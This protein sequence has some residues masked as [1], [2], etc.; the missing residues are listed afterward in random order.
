MFPQFT[1][2]NVIDGQAGVIIYSSLICHSLTIDNI[3]N[4]IVLLI[5]AGVTVATLT[6]DNGLLTKAGEAKKASEQ[7]NLEEEVK[8]ALIEGQTD[9]YFNSNSNIQDKLKSIFEKSYGQGNIDVTKAGKNYKVKV[10]NT[11]TV[12]RIKSDGTVEKYE[13]MAP[14]NVYA[15]LDDNILRLR[16][17]NADDDYKIYADS[18]S[19]V[20]SLNGT[21]TNVTTVDIEEPIAPIT[22]S[23]MFMGLT[24]LSAIEKIENFHTE[25]STSLHG[26]FN[27]CSNLIGLNL[28]SFDTSKVTSMGDMFQNCKKISNIDLS[29]FD[30]SNVT[31]MT[32]MFY[33]CNS[34][35]QIDVSHFD[36]KKVTK[37]D[38]M[39]CNCKLPEQIDVSN[40]DTAKV[41]TFGGMFSGCRNIKYMYL[42][43]FN[44][45]K[46]TIL[47]G[48]FLG[49]ENLIGVDLSSFDTSIVGNMADMFQNCKKI[50][51]I[52]LSSFN[53]SNV[54]N[55]SCMFLNCNSLEK[56]Y[57]SNN[58][59][60][61][62]VINSNSMFTN[63]NNLVG[64]L[65]T[66]SSGGDAT[67]AHIDE[68]ESNPGYFTLK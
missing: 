29:N 9:K 57:V 11:K 48:M 14:T 58:F 16:A 10:K 37:M 23:S 15:K 44:T 38:S 6:G 35:T 25:N 36:T 2:M 60:T 12:Y 27:G 50:S 51:N 31:T 26:M 46:A 63:T 17:T 55:M 18:S 66:I 64:G 62:K 61:T 28:S 65:G 52:D 39:F 34:L 33:N 1:S 59:V 3:L 42:S 20:S 56:I 13:E 24:N 45:S 21:K 30:T 41:T 53:T 43:N 54:S 8:L 7:A 19:I 49:C 22:C 67:Y 47:T 68:G 32:C 40:F 5:L 4:I